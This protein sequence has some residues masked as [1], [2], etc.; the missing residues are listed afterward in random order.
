MG[1]VKGKN[2]TVR[3][4]N[5]TVRG[6]NATV[7][8]TDATVKVSATQ[9]AVLE[10]LSGNGKLTAEEMAKDIGRD[11][12]IIKR[13]IRV[14]KEKDLLHHIGFDKTGYWKVTKSL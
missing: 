12:T 9:K 13:Q 6:K 5:T 3:D 4:K 8:T 10:L 7:K 14:L 11:I 1:T 2:A